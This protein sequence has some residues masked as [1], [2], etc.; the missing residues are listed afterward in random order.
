MSNKERSIK[1][2]DDVIKEIQDGKWT[3]EQLQ[4]LINV[5][6]SN[7]EVTSDEVIEYLFQG[8]FLSNILQT[9]ISE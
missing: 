3:D 6:D 9:K 5:F 7:N 8:W 4:E 1:F 2:L